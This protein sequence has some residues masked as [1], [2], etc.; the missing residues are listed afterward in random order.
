MKQTTELYK[1]SKHGMTSEMARDKKI[2]GH[3][4]E[5]VVATQMK[6]TVIKGTGKVDVVTLNG[7]RVSCKR[8]KK[9]QWSLYSKETMLGNCW[10]ESQKESLINYIDFLPE[11]VEE[12]KKNRNQ[13]RINQYSQDLLNDVKDNPMELI[14]FCCG[15][16]KIDIFHLTDDRTNES[17]LI[18]SSD[19]FHKIENAIKGVYKTNGGKIV[20]SGGVK[21]TIMFELELRKGTNHKKVLFHS[22]LGRIIDI[23]K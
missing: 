9:T 16:G 21:N 1:K 8:G 20:I 11:S 4:N 12:Y 23:V 3:E 5:N 19:F 18:N 22:L 6:G 17:Y 7:D 14:K 15:F 2:S 10:N 13:Y